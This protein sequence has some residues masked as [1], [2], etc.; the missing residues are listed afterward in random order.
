MLK[1]AAPP[2][3][4]GLEY[5][6]LQTLAPWVFEQI[7]A[8]GLVRVQ[9]LLRSHGDNPDEALSIQAWVAAVRQLERDGRLAA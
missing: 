2:P 4:A 8:L 7:N 3:S 6:E 9:D 5:A 1:T